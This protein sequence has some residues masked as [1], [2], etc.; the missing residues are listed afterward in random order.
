MTGDLI[1]NKIVVKIIST[2][3]RSNPGTTSQR[4]EKS[5]EIPKQRYITRKIIDELMLV[6]ASQ[7]AY[8]P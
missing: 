5:M 1:D 3:P 6:S 8:L 4:V 7:C 2:V